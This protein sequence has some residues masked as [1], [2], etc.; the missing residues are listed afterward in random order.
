[1]I[2]EHGLFVGRLGLSR[3]CVVQ[4]GKLEI[5]SDLSGIIPKTLNGNEQLGRIQFE[6]IK[7][8]RKAGYDVDANRLS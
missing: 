3:V 1:M 7:E 6:L 4:T 5:P 8:L 2:Y